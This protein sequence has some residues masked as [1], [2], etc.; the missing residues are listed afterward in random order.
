MS[1]PY[2]HGSLGRETPY[3]YPAFCIAGHESCVTSDEGC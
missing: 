1:L 3:H 2:R